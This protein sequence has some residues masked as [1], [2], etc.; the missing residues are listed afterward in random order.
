MACGGGAS[1]TLP[2]PPPPRAS[3]FAEKPFWSLRGMPLLGRGTRIQRINAWMLGS[4]LGTSHKSSHFILPASCQVCVNSPILQLRKWRLRKMKSLGQGSIAETRLSLDLDA[5]LFPPCFAIFQCQCSISPHPSQPSCP[6]AHSCSL[7]SPPGLL[8]SP[9]SQPSPNCS[10]WTP[11]PSA[12]LVQA[13][14]SLPLSLLPLI[15]GS[16][17]TAIFIPDTGVLNPNH[18]H[19]YMLTKAAID[20]HGL[21]P[22][23]TPQKLGGCLGS[24]N[25]ILPPR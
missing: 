10:V 4:Q 24:L 13:L 3:L 20:S 17:H 7:Q 18:C 25:K 22:R 11:G 8:S 2:P 6:R 14:P 19:C 21:N 1:H 9:G 15:P 23:D 16:P 12:G 5:D